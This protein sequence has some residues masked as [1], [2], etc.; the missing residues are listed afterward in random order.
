MPFFNA[1]PIEMHAQAQVSP[2]NL[3]RSKPVVPIPDSWITKPYVGEA[4]LL[5]LNPLDAH[6]KTL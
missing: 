1:A 2:P 3:S 5:R 6:Q 4:Q